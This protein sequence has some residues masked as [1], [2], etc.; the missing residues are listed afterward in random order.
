[1][2]IMDLI[3]CFVLGVTIALSWR[4]YQW[5]RWATPP[6]EKPISLPPARQPRAIV[7]VPKGFELDRPC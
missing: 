2:N 1:M 6:M 5:T 7:E 3:L 4:S